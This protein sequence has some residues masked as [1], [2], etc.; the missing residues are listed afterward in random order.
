L[1]GIL[2]DSDGLALSKKV[3]KRLDIDMVFLYNNNERLGKN[4]KTETPKRLIM[5]L[6][7]RNGKMVGTTELNERMNGA[8]VLAR[9]TEYG[10]SAFTYANETSAMRARD[11]W[12]HSVMNETLSFDVIR[13]SRVWFV[14]VSER[15]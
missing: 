13:G 3:K 9:L 7:M 1:T 8:T 6:G 2:I 10:M 14:R 5:N 11:R 12:R 15:G 4:P